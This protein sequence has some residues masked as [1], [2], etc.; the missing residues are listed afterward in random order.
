MEVAGHLHIPAAL[1]PWF[2]LVRKLDGPHSRSERSA[3]DKYP[4]PKPGI[5][6][7]F[8]GLPARRLHYK[9]FRHKVRHVELYKQE[10]DSCAFW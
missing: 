9:A 10:P 5:E 6:P 1:P 8:L 4:L 3:E 7:R 2:P